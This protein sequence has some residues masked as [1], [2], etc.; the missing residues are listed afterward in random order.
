MRKAILIIVA[1]MSLSNAYSQELYFVTGSNF[2]KYKFEA[3]GSPMST[4]L[5]SGSGSTYEIGYKIPI[6]NKDFSY[7]FG[8]TL[9]N[10]N[11]VAGSAA[12][13]YEW[14]TKYL[15][16][17]SAFMYTYT[18]SK[19][20]SISARAGVNL[21]S[22]IYG[23]QNI[24]GAIFDLNHQKEFSGLFLSAFGG[25]QTNYKINNLG[26]LSFGYGYSNGT[27][28]SNSTTEKLS[29]KTNQILFGIHFTIN[30]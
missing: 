1:F 25:V 30:H 19:N 8:V 12:N 28:T 7:S 27:N 15:G 9:N 29:F 16:G 17:Q 22:I 20:F 2:T 4:Q 14:N 10:Y 3:N 23:K 5:Q 18:V 11:A 26:Y 21:S 6:R 24:D 13:T